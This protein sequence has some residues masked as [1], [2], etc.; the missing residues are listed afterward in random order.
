MDERCTQFLAE[1]MGDGL[2]FLMGARDL[3]IFHIIG[4]TR[5]TP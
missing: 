5:E 4:V 2:F 1:N 3:V